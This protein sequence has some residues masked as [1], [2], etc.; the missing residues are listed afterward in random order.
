[1]Y[2]EIYAHMV[3]QVAHMYTDIYTHMDDQVAY[4]NTDI[5]T[6]MDGVHTHACACISSDKR[7]VF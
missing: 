4:I 1:M 2:T 3:D 7:A 6:H 5:Y